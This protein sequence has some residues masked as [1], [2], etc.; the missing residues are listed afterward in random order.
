VAPTLGTPADKK[1]HE[2]E[3]RTPEK[4]QERE[5]QPKSNNSTSNARPQNDTGK[6]PSATK[7]NTS[8][9]KPRRSMSVG[10]R[11]S[12]VGASNTSRP[13]PASHPARLDWPGSKY[14]P[15]AEGNR[16]VGD[17]YEY[18]E[19]EEVHQQGQQGPATSTYK[20]YRNGKALIAVRDAFP[21]LLHLSGKADTEDLPVSELQSNTSR[22]SSMELVL[23]RQGNQIYYWTFSLGSSDGRGGKNTSAYFRDTPGVFNSR[24][25]QEDIEAENRAERR[26]QSTSKVDKKLRER[27]K[28]EM[29]KKKVYED[30]SLVILLYNEQVI[31]SFFGNALQLSVIGLYATIVITIGRFIRIIFDRISQRV[32]YEELPNTKQLFEICGGIFIAQQEGDLVREKQ[33]YDLLILMY[34]SPEA[35]IKITGTRLQHKEED[36]SSVIDSAESTSKGSSFSDRKK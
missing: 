21:K 17:D 24:N 35:L 12:P 32:M 31:G 33:L 29:Q 5:K 30:Q 34:R 20:M 4:I 14:A 36:D 19:V 1:A 25:G 13:G 27:E 28:A 26:K 9:T 15:S 23:N 18:R 22:Y 2:P 6:G 16:S 8:T 7:A 3:E 11:L 10:D